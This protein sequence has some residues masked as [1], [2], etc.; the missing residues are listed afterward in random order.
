MKHL[1]SCVVLAVMSCVG[2]DDAAEPVGAGVV[3]GVVRY[4]GSMQGPL[5]VGVFTSFPPRGAPIASVEISSPTY[6]ETYEVPGVPP[7]RYFVLAIVDTDPSDGDRYHPTRDPGG[8]VGRYDDPWS[9]VVDPAG[10]PAQDIELV[11]PRALSP[12]GSRYR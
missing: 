5:R 4:D 1:A 9:V 12:W 7:G 6:P 3:R 2:A 10:T 11:D 8:A